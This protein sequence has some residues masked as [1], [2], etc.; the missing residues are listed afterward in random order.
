MNEEVTKI[1]TDLFDEIVD[2]LADLPYRRVA[3]IF[4]Q[5]ATE[6]QAQQEPKIHI[7]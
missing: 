1:S 5:M 4:R 6:V 2:A 3:A 7:N